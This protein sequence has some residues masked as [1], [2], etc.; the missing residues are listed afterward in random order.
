VVIRLVS[1]GFLS[2]LGFIGG[3]TVTAAAPAPVN[4]PAVMDSR[5]LAYVA[6]TQAKETAAGA[7]AAANV[8]G[9]PIL[10]EVSEPV[11]VGPAYDAVA[12][13][14]FDPSGHPVQVLTYASGRWVPAATLA[15]PSAPGTLRHAAALLLIS[16]ATSITAT[17]LTGTTRPSFL[18]P[19]G[20]GGCS[21]GA[22]VTPGP[23]QGQ[24]RYAPFTGPYPKS[25][26]IGGNPRI[27]G[28]TVVSDN[29]CTATAT[30][31]DQRFSWTW[32]YR[33][34]SKSL[35]GVR[36]LGWPAPVT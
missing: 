14:S 17:R 10:D 32:T 5:L 27:V 30:P 19:L 2:V 29:D 33:A 24:W 8:W 34:A 1:L 21:Q 20:G 31:A 26:V 22:V 16:D 11:R 3:G 9:S 18:I 15:A 6:A 7:G 13:F 4:A 25:E 12:A 35:L 28:D 36:H 23:G